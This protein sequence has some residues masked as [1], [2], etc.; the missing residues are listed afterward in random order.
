MNADRESG[1]AELRVFK[2]KKEL[3]DLALCIPTIGLPIYKR[4][5]R[6]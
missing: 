4:E 1:L 2:S 6:D 3:A 5:T